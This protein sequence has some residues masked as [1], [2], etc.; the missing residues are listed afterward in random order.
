M[1]PIRTSWSSAIEWNPNACT[2]T[3]N[4]NFHTNNKILFRIV[5]EACKKAIDLTEKANEKFDLN[6][7]PTVDKFIKENV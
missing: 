7:D 4:I 6:H 5:E 2:R 3:F 1:S